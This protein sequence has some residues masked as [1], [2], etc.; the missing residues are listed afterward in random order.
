MLKIGMAIRKPS[1]LVLLIFLSSYLLVSNSLAEFPKSIKLEY[2]PEK[3]IETKYKMVIKAETKIERMNGEKYEGENKESKTKGEFIFID[4]ILD[5]DEEIITEEIIYDDVK[6]EIEVGNLKQLLSSMKNLK[7]KSFIVKFNKEGKLFE[8]RGFK[9]LAPDFKDLKIKS[10][11]TQL[12]PIFPEYQ[13]KVGDSWKNDIKST[14][15]IED[16]I[17][18]TKVKSKYILKGFKKEKGYK[19]VVIE[20]EFET[21]TET[22]TLKKDEEFMA[23]VDMKG[24]GKG[25]TIYAYEK[26]KVISSK[27]DMSLKSEVT[28][29]TQLETSILEITQNVDMK[30]EIQ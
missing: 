7:G 3:G 30:L 2:N 16:K 22:T 15:P 10:I 20:I 4:K 27:L 25:E 13:L 21:E 11:Y 23:D 28:T 14:L 6:M 8:S 26:S 17:V 9:A 24:K 1:F 29:Q 19:C 12:N 18:K 5:V